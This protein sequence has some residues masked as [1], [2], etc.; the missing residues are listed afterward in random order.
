MP[1]KNTVEKT[2]ELRRKH[3]SIACTL[4]ALSGDKETKIKFSKTNLYKLNSQLKEV[5]LPELPES[6]NSFEYSVLRK[7]SCL[8]TLRACTMS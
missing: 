5:I 8:C 3:D 2:D 6:H 1:T 7:L 4:R